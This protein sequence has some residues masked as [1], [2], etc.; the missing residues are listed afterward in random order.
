MKWTLLKVRKFMD[1]VESPSA[2]VED[3]EKY[4]AKVNGKL[5]NHREM[6]GAAYR[7]GPGE[8]LFACLKDKAA[9]Q[10]KITFFEDKGAFIED[11]SERY[12]PSERPPLDF[13][14]IDPYYS[15][16]TGTP[17]GRVAGTPEELQFAKEV[18]DFLIGKGW[19]VSNWDKLELTFC[20]AYYDDVAF[21]RRLRASGD[22]CFSLRTNYASDN[23]SLLQF[24]MHR[25]AYD[26]IDFLVESGMPLRSCY[27]GAVEPKRPDRGDVPAWRP[28]HVDYLLSKGVPLHFDQYSV[29]CD[30]DMYCYAFE[31]LG[32]KNLR[33][34]RTEMKNLAPM[35]ANVF[36]SQ[37]FDIGDYLLQ[38][39]VSKPRGTVDLREPSSAAID[40]GLSRGFKLRIHVDNDKDILL[41][42]AKRG[43]GPYGTAVIKSFSHEKK[44]IMGPGCEK[45]EG[46]QAICEML[47]EEVITA[48]LDA[49]F[50]EG[51]DTSTAIE[52]GCE[53]LLESYR[54]H[55]IS[56]ALKRAYRHTLYL[57][58]QKAVI[59]EGVEEVA[60]SAFATAD[61]NSIQLPSTLKT[62]GQEAFW[63]LDY[64][65]PPASVVVPPNVEHI[66]AG[67]FAGW[68][69]ITIYDTLDKNAA[70]A[71]EKINLCDGFC[72]GEAG[73]MTLATDHARVYDGRIAGTAQHTRSN[74]HQVIVRSAETGKVKY[75]V[76]M[77]L[78][79]ATIDVRHTFVSAWGRNATFH[80]PALDAMFEKL[81]NKEA[82][83]KAAI[84]RLLWPISL[85]P[86]VREI[87][88]GYL[89][90]LAKS[91][92][93]VAAR[94]NDMDGLGLLEGMGLVKSTNIEEG[95]KAAKDANSEE[96]LQF[97]KTYKAE[98]F[99]PQRK[100]NAKKP[101][102]SGRSAS[103]KKPASQKKPSS[104]KKSTNPKRSVNPKKPAKQ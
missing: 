59:P 62:I 22:L 104:T 79:S 29:N 42:A 49:G 21:L 33:T 24:L 96:A 37:R 55:G 35:W 10:E 68:Q 23:Y 17:G 95:I 64:G 1:L 78:E 36:R 32:P 48:F 18:F 52:W 90:R 14:E 77:P 82:K 87:Y 97:L 41:Y 88:E 28:S 61:M 101:A 53:G 15:V 103:T 75:R 7:Q 93:Q 69:Q 71:G 85:E 63:R 100:A 16:L 91:A 13:R 94:M 19:R 72:N 12:W 67:A 74:D 58:G 98:H 73:W 40:W 8:F 76:D 31:K 4:M 26:A 20:Y 2:S 44:L 3:L 30:F 57:D 92:V 6:R 56:V 51:V 99:P 60:V 43:L 39:G 34:T 46:M 47:D 9:Y 86:E 25:S 50:G 81:P 83:I 27:V 54:R 89:H 84:N 70:G 5:P 102:G 38:Q 80:F 11:V 66:G 45:H 65:K